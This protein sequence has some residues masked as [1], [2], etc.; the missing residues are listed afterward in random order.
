[1]D[2]DDLVSA[3]LQSFVN[4]SEV[5]IDGQEMIAFLRSWTSGDRLGNLCARDPII[6]CLVLGML[7]HD[8]VLATHHCCINM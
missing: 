4:D 8:Q 7:S 6:V 3:I 1:M 5:A 2:C